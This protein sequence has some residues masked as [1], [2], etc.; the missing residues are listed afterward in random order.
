MF[1]L[2]KG[3]KVTS[4]QKQTR[5][6]RIKIINRFLFCNP[7]LTM[8]FRNFTIFLF[9]AFFLSCGTTKQIDIYNPFPDKDIRIEQKN[10]SCADTYEIKLWYFL[11]GSYPINTVNVRELFPTADYTY[12]IEQNATLGDKV[13]SFFTGLFFSVSRKTLLVKTCQA[14][15]MNDTE[16][17]ETN[18]TEEKPELPS[19]QLNSKV[20]ELEKE[21]SFL[22]GKISGIETTVG[23]MNPPSH[24]ITQRDESKILSSE[25]NIGNSIVK[26]SEQNATEVTH[27][28]LLFKTGSALVTKNE[29]GKLQ[30]LKALFN[31]PWSK[32]LII[33]SADTSGNFKSNLNLSWKRA[34]EVKNL[35]VAEGISP[36][37]ILISGAG[38]RKQTEES[39]V[40]E[41]TRR[42]DIYFVNGGVK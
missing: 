13:L 25:A 24:D 11:Y 32:I 14:I 20:E 37:R 3:K 23:W 26:N 4:F 42:V 5:I 18:T 9:L 31:K 16:P 8:I 1:S 40:V 34:L 17:E 19:T 27:H 41:V 12:S 10:R 29:L 28:F 33:G 35:L 7:Q 22:K 2:N 39:K 21:V 15:A 30:K 6:S 38:E 36:Q